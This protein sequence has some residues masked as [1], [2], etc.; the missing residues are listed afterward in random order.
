M[1][2]ILFVLCFFIDSV[3]ASVYVSPNPEL[4]IFD[5]L[6][7]EDADFQHDI[8]SISGQVWLILYIF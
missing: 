7:E 6:D 3:S 2:K 8:S 1:D 4:N 5:G